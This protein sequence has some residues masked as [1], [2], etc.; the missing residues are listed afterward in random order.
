MTTKR[1][2]LEEVAFHYLKEFSA[3]TGIIRP[4]GN[5]YY[6]KDYVRA[7]CRRL[8]KEECDFLN[9][10]FHSDKPADATSKRFKV[11]FYPDEKLVREQFLAFLVHE[12]VEDTTDEVV[13]NEFPI[14]GVRSDINRFNGKSYTYE[15]KSPRDS[16][17]RLGKQLDTYSRVFENVYLVI[18]EDTDE[19]NHDHESVGVFTYNFPAF[20]FQMEKKATSIT[21]L[22]P[23]LQLKQLRLPELQIHLENRDLD[24]VASKERAV[25]QITSSSSPEEVNSIFK[26]TIKERYTG[27]L[28]M[29]ISI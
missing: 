6:K 24:E 9:N 20:E 5:Y 23:E 26:E 19:Y 4:R 7:L 21:D 14:S 15:L 28:D 8:K 29:D 22:D 1:E 12:L 25:S 11:E 2:L 16:S 13:F 27:G 18:P 17:A 3:Y 10:Q